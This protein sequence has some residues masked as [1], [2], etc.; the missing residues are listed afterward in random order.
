MSKLD[1]S[2]SLGRVRLGRREFCRTAAGLVAAATTIGCSRASSGSGS[3]PELV[4]GQVGIVDGRFQ[5]PRAIT[6][7][8]DDHLYIV[9]MTA[10]IQVFDRDGKF[11]R[12]WQTPTHVNGRPTGL[13][14]SR[15]GLLVVADTHYFRLLFYTR[16]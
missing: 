16:D 7:D 8:A 6:I 13:S 14:I 4:W 15:D 3:E 11:L 1:D 12:M 9:D 2:N 5:K 10:R